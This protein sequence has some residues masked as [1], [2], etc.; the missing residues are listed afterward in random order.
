MTDV[1]GD[2]T[3][4]LTKMIPVGVA[5]G[6]LHGAMRR[7]TPKRRSSVVKRKPVKRKVVVRRVV[8]RPPKRRKR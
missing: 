1:F 8:R 6:M 7:V 3:T 2:T 4:T 5:A